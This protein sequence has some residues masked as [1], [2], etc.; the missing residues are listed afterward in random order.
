MTSK[1]QI[2]NL[3][4]SRLGASTITALTDNTT[5]AKLCSTFF[6]DIAD[7]VMMEGSW[8]STVKRAS[9][10]KTTNT[11]A[12]QYSSE[13]QLPVDPFCLKV[14]N[15]DEDTPGDISYRVEGDK[16]VSDNA[17][18]KI[19]YI[20]RL[21]DTEDWDILL[22]RAFVARLASE[23]A[24]PLTGDAAKVQ[25]EFELYQFFVKEGLAIDG[26]QGSKEIVTSVDLIEVR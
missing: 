22:R 6:N 21:T 15:I 17:S 25:A 8:T 14:L 26:Q 7:E 5:E 18:M 23:L 2:C 24:Y 20:A 3:A 1:V 12:F 13:F 9:L 19:R 10:A 11:P 4:L 16:I